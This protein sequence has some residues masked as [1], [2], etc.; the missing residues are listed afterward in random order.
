MVTIFLADSQRV[1]YTATVGKCKSESDVSQGG[2]VCF[3]I[4]Q[5]YFH[6]DRDLFFPHFFGNH[7]GK[8]IGECTV[9]VDGNTQH[10]IVADAL[11]FPLVRLPSLRSS[12]LFLLMPDIE[13][14]AAS[15]TY[16]CYDDC[17][18]YFLHDLYF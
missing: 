5:S 18:Y 6:T 1:R 7:G 10:L 2:E 12:C 16:Q 14:N 13:V 15:D 4:T 9:V 11:Y 17:N 3:G 8:G